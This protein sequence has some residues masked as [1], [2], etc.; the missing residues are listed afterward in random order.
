MASSGS[1]ENI[2]ARDAYALRVEWKVNSQNIANNTSNITFNVYLVSYE[3]WATISSS[4]EKQVL[5]RVNN[6][7]VATNIADGLASLSGNQKKRILTTT[8]NLKHD[9]DGTKTLTVKA[10]FDIEVTLSGTKYNTVNAPASGTK[11]ITLDRIP[12]TS[13]PST[14]GTL[15]VGSEIVINLDVQ[16]EWFTHTLQ[17]SLDKSSWTN[18]ATNVGSATTWTLPSSLATA[19]PNAKTGTVYIR[20]ITYDGSTN[21]GNE[22]ISRTYNITSSYASPSVALAASQTNSAGLAMYVRG[23]SSVTLKA[24][25]TLKYGASAQKYVFTYGGISKTITS[26]S[27]SASVTF[28]LPSNAAASFACSVTLTDSRGFTASKSVSIT[29]VAYSA[30]AI[31]SLSVLRGDYVNGTFTQNDKG[32]SLHIAVTGTITSLSNANAKN[33]KIEYRLSN[34]TAYTTLIDTKAA[35]AYAVAI[36]E[37]TDAIFSENAAYVIRFTLSDSFDSVSQI[38]DVPSQKVLLNFSANGKAMSIGGIASVDDAL[39]IMLEAY[40]TGGIKPMQLA[41][42]TDFNEI[43]KTGFYIGNA[44]NSSFANTPTAIN[45]GS[46]MLWVF[47]SGDS[48]QLMQRCMYS[49]KTAYRAYVRFY[50]G[51]SWGEWQPAEGFTYYNTTGYA[52]QIRLANGFMIQWGRVSI[53]TTT[54]NVTASVDITYPV[55]FYH[56]P[57]VHAHAHTGAPDVVSVSCG[58]GGV[59]G[60]T[61]YLNRANT[62]AT[63][64]TWI[65]IGRGAA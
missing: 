54:A 64:V 38:Y 60:T 30:P 42:D 46:F 27:A 52:G 59:S 16:G 2:F 45:S 58:V 19:K 10:E 17:Y 8:Y 12:R 43:V 53:A 18:I 49:N 28:K 48:G 4:A 1:F 44:N 26:T 31:S 37:Y 32:N 7:I 41:Q 62:V 29:T 50:Y 34:Q 20:C 47:S 56:A 15:N 23:E 11:S 21:L 39:E 55:T 5:L 36:T 65:A 33:Y 14:S 57:V 6:A 51:E 22:V 24:T 13:T 9:T 61:L 25:A 35:S 40:M 63:W 3:S